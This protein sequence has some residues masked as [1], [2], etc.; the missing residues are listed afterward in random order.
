M[1]WA[2]ATGTAGPWA[3]LDD[4]A[5]KCLL[6]GGLGKAVKSSL[7]A[8]SF[9]SRSCYLCRGLS[10]MIAR[11]AGSRLGRPRAGK[12]QQH[13]GSSIRRRETDRHWTSVQNRVRS[14]NVGIRRT[15]GRG[16]RCTA[17]RR[18][19]SRGTWSGGGGGLSWNTGVV[20]NL[21]SP[22]RQGPW[23]PAYCLACKIIR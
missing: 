5:C 8:S 9:S 17:A 16:L 13:A 14:G 6:P 7:G 15:G 19:R 22:E 20:W 23:G 18:R 11:P 2:D 3:V 12:Q 21:P 4:A 1:T 10:R